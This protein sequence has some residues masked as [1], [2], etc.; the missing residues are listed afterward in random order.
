MK[1][2]KFKVTNPP[3]NPPLIEIEESDSILNLYDTTNP[4]REL[5]NLVDDEVIRLSGSKIYFYKYYESKEFDEVYME[6]RSKTISKDPIILFAHYEPKPLE[7]NLSQFGIETSNDQVFTFN[8]HYVE[9]R[10]G[11]EI[12]PGDVIKP[13]FQNMRYRV[14]QVQ[15]DAFNAFG[16][17]H[18]VC[19][20]NLLRDTEDIHNEEINPPPDVG[21]RIVN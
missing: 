5:F 7:Q 6:S 20:C 9:R 8:K 11:R 4:D 21:G 16:V 1:S 14:F 10:I 17:Y 2:D 12:V 13:F 15:E 3:K 18:L 19:Y